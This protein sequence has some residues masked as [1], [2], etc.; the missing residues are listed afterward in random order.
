MIA[1]QNCFNLIKNFEGFRSGAYL[2]QAG[3]PTIG[4]G[5]THY[6]NGVQVKMGDASMSEQQG[7]YYLTLVIQPYEQA[8]NDFVTVTLNQNQF[9]ALVDFCYNLGQ[10]ALKTSTLLDILNKGDY[11]GASEQFPLWCHCD[12]VKNQG[13]LNRRLAEQSLF[14]TEVSNV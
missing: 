10:N 13:L 5:F 1:S 6:P 14:N 9:D 2:D 11:K 7:D 12:G 4:Y 3:I 8:I